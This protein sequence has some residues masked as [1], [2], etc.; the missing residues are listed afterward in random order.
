MLPSVEPTRPVVEHKQDAIGRRL[1]VL[2]PREPHYL[3]HI[4]T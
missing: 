2:S 1:A 4:D 3:V